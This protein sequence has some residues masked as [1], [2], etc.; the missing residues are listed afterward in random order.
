MNKLAKVKSHLRT[1]LFE[2][3]CKP[4]T[5]HKSYIE[6]RDSIEL[7][8]SMIKL[9]YCLQYK[10]AGEDH[11]TAILFIDAQLEKINAHA[12]FTREEDRLEMIQTLHAAQQNNEKG[13]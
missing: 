1:Q 6:I 9:N 4:I 8:I 7:L 13:R 11:T 2:E 12:S 3:L 10:Y 5:S